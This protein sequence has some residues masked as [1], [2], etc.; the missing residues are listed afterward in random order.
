ECPRESALLLSIGQE[1]LR[2]RSFHRRSKWWDRQR[3]VLD[4]LVT[5]SRAEYSDQLAAGVPRTKPQ[6]LQRHSKF[7]DCPAPARTFPGHSS[8]H[9]GLERFDESRRYHLRDRVLLWR[10]E[11]DH[12][13]HRAPVPRYKTVA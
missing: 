10:P 6:P 5:L 7:Q 9:R 13:S 12:C 4:P 11:P 8:S 2:R 1:S 3:R